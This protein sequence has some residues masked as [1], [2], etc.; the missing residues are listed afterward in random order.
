DDLTLRPSSLSLHDAL[1]I[2]QPSW[3]VDDGQPSPQPARLPAPQGCRALQGTDPETGPASL[4]DT[5]T[6]AQ[7]CAAVSVSESIQGIPTWRDRKSTR[8][9]SSHVKISYAV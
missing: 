3:P 9:N 5:T 1:P 8:L 2:S 7:Q 4:S 6:A